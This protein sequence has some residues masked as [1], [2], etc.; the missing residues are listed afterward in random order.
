MYG[1]NPLHRNGGLFTIQT[2][3]PYYFAT[4]T[5]FGL[6]GFNGK[7]QSAFGFAFRLQLRE[8]AE[9][10]IHLPLPL[11]FLR[12]IYIERMTLGQPACDGGA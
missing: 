3:L 12:R 6:G 5:S 11:V 10:P 9:G 8:Q 2:C 1:S 7:F 4:G